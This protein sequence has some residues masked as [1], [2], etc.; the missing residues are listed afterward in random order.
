MSSV[1]MPADAAASGLSSADAVASIGQAGAEAGGQLATGALAGTTE[2]GLNAVGSIVPSSAIDASL[3]GAGALATGGGGGLTIPK[4]AA[5]SVPSSISG[6]AATPAATPGIGSTNAG[7]LGGASAGAAPVGTSVGAAGGDFSGQ[8]IGSNNFMGAN[9]VA[10]GT[11]Q[12]GVLTLDPSMD[13]GGAA[14]DLTGAP[15]GGGGGA[16]VDSGSGWS[17]AAAPSTTP[18]LD[19]FTANPGVGTA[20][21]LVKANPNIALSTLGLGANLVLGNQKLPGQNQISSLAGQTAQQSAQ[22]E[23]YLQTGTLPPGLQA[24][25]TSA[26]AAAKAT[27]RSRHAAQGTSGSSSEEQE[28]AAVDTGLQTQ[29]ANVALQLFQQGMSEAQISAQLYQSI[30]SSAVQQDAELGSAIGRFASSLA[31]TTTINLTGH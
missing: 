3:S 25:L 20:W 27:I 2:T 18:N 1:T 9:A 24:G 22:L 14:K 26:G 5:G 28:L 10:P 13:T 19:A 8:T 17:N 4:S 23:S 6:G 30:L 16:P 11:M 7:V 21:D 15:V 12:S 31:P 29:G